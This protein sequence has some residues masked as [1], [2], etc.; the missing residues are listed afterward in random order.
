MIFRLKIV[1]SYQICQRRVSLVIERFF[2]VT[3]TRLRFS[4]EFTFTLRSFWGGG[5]FDY[6]PTYLVVSAG[7]EGFIIFVVFF[8]PLVPYAYDLSLRAF[9]GERS[10]GF[11]LD[12]PFGM[13][14]IGGVI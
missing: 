11:Y 4:C 14:G 1:C 5:V 3:T 12:G 7:C 8:G 9:L 10:L 2:P 6:S 13:L